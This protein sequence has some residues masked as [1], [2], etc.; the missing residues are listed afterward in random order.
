MATLLMFLALSIPQGWTFQPPSAVVAGSHRAAGRQ[1]SVLTRRAMSESGASGEK[2]KRGFDELM[3]FA[4]ESFQD[5]T[6]SRV[7]DADAE[8][9]IR[10]IVEAALERG[11]EEL[12][13]LGDEILREQ[14]AS[15][16]PLSA[17][18]LQLYESLQEKRQQAN[19]YETKVAALTDKVKKE[20][21]TIE[22]EVANLKALQNK[23]END[24]LIRIA[25][26]GSQP[27]WRKSLLGVSLLL[28]I[29]SVSDVMTG[30]LTN[31][32]IHGVADAGQFA[33]SIAALAAYMFI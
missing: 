22:S 2:E 8:E 32:D 19:L 1:C 9:K 21:E 26:Y 13:E 18:M 33:G 25:T 29:R 5:S 7:L 24:P 10:K 4:R 28:F 30:V 14:A 3:A 11:G 15:E 6:D 12:K 23:M 20:T 31:T 17:E 27:F 16:E